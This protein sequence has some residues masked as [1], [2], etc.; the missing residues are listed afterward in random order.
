[1]GITIPFKRGDT[2]ELFC[3]YT[4]DG[5]PS[6]IPPV[7]KSQLRDRAGSLVADLDALITDSANGEY[8][9]STPD[10]SMFPVDTLRQDI[11]YI[12]SLGNIM[13]TETFSVEVS[14]NVTDA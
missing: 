7:V 6:P 11:R 3:T 10:S 8:I 1:M 9:L 2:F 12:D 14:R 13:T 4:L 5:I